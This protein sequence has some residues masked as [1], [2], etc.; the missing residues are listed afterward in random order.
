MDDDE[1]V[2][3]IGWAVKQMRLGFRV[4]RTGWNGK[5]MWLG[6]INPGE[7]PRYPRQNTDMDQPY[8]FIR[9]MQDQWVPWVC[10]QTDLLATD[11]EIAE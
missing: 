2:C 11:W 3:D 9:T 10:S 4:R 7:D 6:I 5:G 1:Q 8:V